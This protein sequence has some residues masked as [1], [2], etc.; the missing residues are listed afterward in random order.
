MPVAFDLPKNALGQDEFG[1]NSA[2]PYRQV[3]T[4]R[5]E[6]TRKLDIGDRAM[7]ESEPFLIHF[8]EARKLLGLSPS[9]MTLRVRRNIIPRVMIGER[10]LFRLQAIRELAEKGGYLEL[11]NQQ[12]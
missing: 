9:Q 12:E 4:I 8:K 2:R 11:P 7:T 6:K 3:R 10:Q 1:R 5:R